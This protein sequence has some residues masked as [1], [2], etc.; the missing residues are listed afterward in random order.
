MRTLWSLLLFA[1]IAFPRTPFWAPLAPPRAHYTASVTYTPSTSRLEGTETIAF[2]ND[3]SRPF[4]RLALQ[5]FGDSLAV[6]T[7]GTVLPRVPGIQQG[8]AL[9]DLPNDV[10]PGGEIALSV[11]FG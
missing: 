9:F 1:G 8:V 3:T 4:G 7:A 2:H 10:P 11:T 6:R 5:W